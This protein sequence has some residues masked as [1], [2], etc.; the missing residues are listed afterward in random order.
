MPEARQSLSRTSSP[1]LQSHARYSNLPVVGERRDTSTREV[2]ILFPKGCTICR[3]PRQACSHRVPTQRRLLLRNRLCA[4]CCSWSSRGREAHEFR[5]RCL[6]SS[7]R[8]E[9]VFE[10]PCSD[11]LY[12]CE[13]K[14]GFCRGI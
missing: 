6:V 8:S 2:P 1:P 9:L 14:R 12:G 13:L 11:E 5:A 7:K 3:R 10:H 4:T